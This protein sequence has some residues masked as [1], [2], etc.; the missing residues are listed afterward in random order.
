MS[1]LF[2]KG[3]EPMCAYCSLGSDVTKDEIICRRYGIVE[4]YDW[5]SRFKY[6]PYRRSPPRPPRLKRVEI[7][8]LQSE[9]T[10]E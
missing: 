5:C 2:R 6:D 1:M 7:A 4:P 3:I 8:G 9:F 10:K